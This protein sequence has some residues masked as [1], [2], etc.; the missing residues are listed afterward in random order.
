M[1]RVDALYVI[2]MAA[3]RQ[4]GVVTADQCRAAGLSGDEVRS[5]CR[6]KEWVRLNRG[7]YLVD[8]DLVDGVP[9]LSAIRAAAFSTGPDAVA[10]LA[11]AAELHGIAGLRRDDEIHL[12]LPK[13][14][15]R[16]FLF[17]RQQCR[18]A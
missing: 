15:L 10:V 3:A 1:P 4:H 6:A 7:A 13:R 9:R 16:S 12:S 11:T 17:R 8:A 14:C 2:R 5:L 18:K